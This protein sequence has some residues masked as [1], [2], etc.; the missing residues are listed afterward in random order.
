MIDLPKNKRL[1][2]E[3]HPEQEKGIENEVDKHDVDSVS[4]GSEAS[5]YTELYK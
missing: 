2:T 5:I 3:Q 1:S 4:P